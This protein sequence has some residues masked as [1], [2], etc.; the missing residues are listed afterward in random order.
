MKK[1]RL[2]LMILMFSLGTLIQVNA[3][4]RKAAP[5]PNEVPADIRVMLN[6]LDE[7]KEMDKSA[8]TRV[9][10]KY[11]RKDVR[12]I[13][14]DLRASGNGLYISAGAIIIILLLILIL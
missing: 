7:I 13:K 8:L 3:S 2:Y 14:A 11:L 1:S 4:E 6:R 5:V 10:K 12:T 9:D